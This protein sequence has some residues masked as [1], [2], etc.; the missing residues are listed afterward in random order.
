MN[1]YPLDTVLN[2]AVFAYLGLLIWL[3]VRPEEESA[4]EE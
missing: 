3:A 1:G 4:P 2:L